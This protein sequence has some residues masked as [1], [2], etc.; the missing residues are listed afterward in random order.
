[1]QMAANWK[2]M[3]WGVLVIPFL[4]LGAWLVGLYQRVNTPLA[5]FRLPTLHVV[6]ADP[7][8][9]PLASD[10]AQGRGQRNYAPLAAFLETQLRR[11]VDLVYSDDPAAVLRAHRGAIDLIV[12][13]ASAVSF[14]ATEANEPVR[15]IARLAGKDG[16]TEVCGLFV[17]RK[18]DPARTV[19]DLADHRILFG[20]PGDD[21]RHAAA[22]AMLA[23]EGVTPV[24]PLQT[25]AD[26]GQAVR[27]VVN[28]EADVA[29]IPDYAAANPQDDEPINQGVLRIVGR[30]APVPFIAVFATE[31]V[32]P[33]AQRTM[34]DALFAAGRDAP[35]L[36]ALHSK[37]GFVAWDAPCASPSPPAGNEPAAAAA[38]AAPATAWTDWRGPARAALSPDVPVTLPDKIN[39]LWKRGLTGPGL[40]GVAATTT[41]VIVADKNERSDQD[42]WRCLDAETGKELW[43]LT[44]GT[45]TKMEFTNAPRATPVIHG[46][47]VYLLGAFGDLY[48]VSLYDGRVFWRRNIIEDFGAKLPPWG[49]C[50]TPLVVDDI[51]VVNP[52]AEDASLVALGLYA[53]EV[54][55]QAP[56]EPAA[57]ASLILGT[58]GGVRQI[59]GYDAVSLG[60]WDPNTGRRLWKLLP[61]RKGDYNVPTPINVAGRLL[62]ATENNGAR[63]YG[64]DDQG[65][66]VPAPLAR[67]RRFAP[68]TS[69]P[70]V[71]DGLVFGNW[72]GLYC[73]DANDLQTRYRVDND[74]A[75]NNYVAFIAGNGHVLALTMHG[76]LVLLQAVPEGFTP[77]SRLQVFQDTEVWSHPA[78]VGN[79]L[80]LRSMKEI[81][82]LLLDN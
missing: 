6:I 10:A 4:V 21:G 68:D 31:K 2:K 70:V 22:L 79:R 78:L 8:C 27:T 11:S 33:G 30:T 36:E 50:A 18:N 7:L 19:G 38:S 26:R 12:G 52:G 17:V 56:G 54:A 40:A 47:F 34:L 59:V 16:A 39:L 44:Y 35:L 62:V 57:Y 72:R 5:V 28:G 3:L 75:F 80:Y 58:F 41:H 15:P 43:N 53:G 25:M 1:M 20:P 51:L 73:L 64:F 60:G 37:A 32:S 24:P 14:A 9:R 69:T 81:C 82:C 76:E 65:Q 61:D 66:I 77:V 49:T 23:V 71:V 13:K 48:C 55:W 46:G 29:I 45:P 67:N 42:I 74:K 63:L